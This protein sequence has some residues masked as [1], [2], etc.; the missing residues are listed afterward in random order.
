MLSIKSPSC[1]LFSSFFTDRGGNNTGIFSIKR[2]P[3]SL[4]RVFLHSTPSPIQH[5]TF[6][7]YLTLNMRTSTILTL[8]LEST[9]VFAQGYI[10]S[11][12][13]HLQ[14]LYLN[15]DLVFFRAPGGNNNG[16]QT[17]SSVCLD[18]CIGNN[19]G[20]LVVC[21]PRPLLLPLNCAN[22]KCLF[23]ATSKVSLL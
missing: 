21:G 11:C 15:G 22:L 9:L 8:L 16:Q 23:A 12:D 13:V 4:T 3:L 18:C 20:V 7:S 17:D 6:H 1:K 10:G 5:Q 19:N 2:A 14:S